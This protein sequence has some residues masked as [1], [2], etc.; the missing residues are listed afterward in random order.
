MDITV[1][2]ATPLI[3]PSEV[4]IHNNVYETFSSAIQHAETKFDVYSRDAGILQHSTGNHSYSMQAREVSQFLMLYSFLVTFYKMIQH[5]YIE[6][7]TMY[8][9][10][11]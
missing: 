9:R 4:W 6:Q 11:S 8:I 3:V 1:T 10:K 7:S 5:S 2:A